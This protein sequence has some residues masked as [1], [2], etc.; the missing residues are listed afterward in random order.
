MKKY[1]NEREK[2]IEERTRL[3]ERK[4]LEVEQKFDVDKFKTKTY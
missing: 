4:F 3:R 2:L 1:D